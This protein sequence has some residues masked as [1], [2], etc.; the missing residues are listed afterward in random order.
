MTDWREQDELKRAQDAARQWEE[1]KTIA[2][3]AAT[4]LTSLPSAGDGDENPVKSAI[5]IAA[6]LLEIAQAKVKS[7]GEGLG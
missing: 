2:T 1:A 5:D 7:R 3:L 6:G 4:V